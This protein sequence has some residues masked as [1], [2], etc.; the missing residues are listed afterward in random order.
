MKLKRVFFV[1]LVFVLVTAALP[2]SGYTVE[3]QLGTVNIPGIG[4]RP[5]VKICWIGGCLNAYC[6]DPELFSRV[7]RLPPPNGTRCENLPSGSL[8]CGDAYQEMIPYEIWYHPTNTPT[9]T[10][11]ATATFT[12][13]PTFTAT[14]TATETPTETPLPTSTETPLPTATGTLVPTETQ[15]PT[16]TPLPT[17]TRKPTEEEQPTATRTPEVVITT[18]RT[19]S[20]NPIV[21][22]VPGGLVLLAVFFF[23]KKKKTI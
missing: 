11:T 10:A 4:E 7:D 16:E 20:L 1:M 17:E 2:T 3:Q 5:A 9:P 13:T 19:G 14:A 8:W 12:A 21:Y 6:G 15:A 22:L 18:T 23:L